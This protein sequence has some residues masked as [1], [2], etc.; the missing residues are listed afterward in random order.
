[1][2]PIHIRGTAVRIALPIALVAAI[3]TFV[4]GFRRMH[5]GANNQPADRF[6]Q[7]RAPLRNVPSLENAEK[8][9]LETRLLQRQLSV[10]GLMMA[11]LQAASV[12]VALL[13]AIL[14]FFVGFGQLRQGTDNRAADRFDKALTRL[15]DKRPEERMTGVSGLGLFLSDANPL[16]QKQA[17]QF[18][19]NGLSMETDTRVRGAILDA[20]ADLLPGSASQAMLD[21]GLRTAIERNRSLTKTITSSLPGRI[22]N[23]K[24]QTLEQLK[25]PNLNLDA[26][27]VTIPAQVIAA[28]TTEQYLALL[29]AEQGPFELL[30]PSEDV[31]LT[32]LSSAI[33]MLVKRGAA[34]RDFKEIYCEMCDFK[35]AKSLDNAAFDGADLMGADFAHVSLRG[36]S[37][38]NAD[39]G[40]TIFFDADLT[41]ANLRLGWRRHM[42][43]RGLGSQLPLLE[44]AKLGGADLSGQP[45]VLFQKNFDTTLG[46]SRRIALVCPG[47]S[48]FNWTHLPSSTTSRSSLRLELRTTI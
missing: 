17:I 21:A 35:A 36:A 33:E 46:G 30:D 9:A 6:G 32:G 34:S 14:A 4:A 42:A 31:P 23:R 5:Q 22:E 16:L 39:L 41:K 8:I 2:S 48:R 44:C 10:H 24:K 11:W 45:L 18:L 27:D 40:G 29:D 3:L 28:L 15:A 47:C 1:M 20:I 12:P 25:V 38:E 37:F 13:G 43:S 19:V 7:A 26:M